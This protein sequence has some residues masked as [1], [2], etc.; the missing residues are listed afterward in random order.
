MRTTVLPSVERMRQISSCKVARVRASSA[1]SGSSSSRIC[2]SIAV[3]RAT[4]TRCRMPPESSLGFFV[5][6]GREIHQRDVFLH[7]LD[8]LGGGPVGIHLIHGELDVFKHR[9]PRQQ[10]VILKHHAAI[11]ARFGDL[12]IVELRRA[13][14][15]PEQ[16]P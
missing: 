8:S 12:Q 14:I 7:V 2:G 6:G 16:N 4:L 13:G 1:E 10:R 11:R 15:G 9:E 5:A 3:A